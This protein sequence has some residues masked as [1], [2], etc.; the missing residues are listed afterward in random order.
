MQK[1][2][3]RRKTAIA[4]K[5]KNHTHNEAPLDIFSATKLFRSKSIIKRAKKTHIK[6]LYTNIIHVKEVA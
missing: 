1:K 4:K 2:I 5:K 3:K 6:Q